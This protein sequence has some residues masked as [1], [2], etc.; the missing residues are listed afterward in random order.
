MSLTPRQ[1]ELLRYI[2]SCQPISPSI[3]EMAVHVGI[4]GAE[5]GRGKG[6]ISYSLRALEERGYIRRLAYRARAIEV[7]RPLTPFTPAE[8]R[9]RVVHGPAHWE[10][11]ARHNRARYAAEAAA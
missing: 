10:N 11:V 5:F 7:L 9:L 1:A 3:R 2:E 4:A 8:P 6:S